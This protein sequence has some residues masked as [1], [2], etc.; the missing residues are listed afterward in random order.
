M[1]RDY[2]TG[3]A[4]A[5]TY[6]T[7]VEI[8]KTPAF[9]LKTLFVVGVQAPENI[10]DLATHEKCEHLY[11]GANQSFDG[12]NIGDWDQMI[13]HCLRLGY[14]CTLDFDIK[15][16]TSNQKWLRSLSIFE[17]TFIPQ[18]S[19]KIPGLTDYNKNATV[20]IDDID[21]RATN[22]GVWCHN[23]EKLQSNDQF[24]D[25]IEYGNDEIIKEKSS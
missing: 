8:E 13:S 16:C 9:G 7:G 23:L 20:K 24:T 18:I 2:T 21:F 4:E 1:K 5:I 19:V 15:F 14:K 3:Q 25:W 17:D 11:F 10:I 22:P 12:N 6:F